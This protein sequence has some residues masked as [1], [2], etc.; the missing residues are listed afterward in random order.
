MKTGKNLVPKSRHQS[1]RKQNATPCRPHT[2]CAS[3]ILVEKENVH[4][5]FETNG[6][7]MHIMCQRKMD[8]PSLWHTRT[9]TKC[10][11]LWLTQCASTDQVS[12][13]TLLTDSRAGPSQQVFNSWDYNW[14]LVYASLALS[15]GLLCLKCQH[16]P[17]P[18]PPTPVFFFF[19]NINVQLLTINRSVRLARYII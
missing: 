1:G 17:P 5:P 3:I 15:M 4:P 13:L 11:A 19:H 16:F 12:K 7:K 10:T 18:P 9:H 14:I 2:K 6:P 8:K